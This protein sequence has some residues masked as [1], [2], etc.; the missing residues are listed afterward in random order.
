MNI[1][2]L[3]NSRFGVGLAITLCRLLPTESG[4]RLASW[5][6]RNLANRK[7]LDLVRALR[8]NQWVASGCT[9]SSAELDRRV[10]Q[11][12]AH[13]ARCIFDLYHNLH[14]DEIIHQMIAVS[15]KNYEFLAQ[16]Q[17]ASEGL[18]LGFLHMSNFDF[19]AQAAGMTG[20]KATLLAAEDPGGGGYDL[21]NRLR[22]ESGLNVMTATKSAVR[23][24]IRLLQHGGTVATGLDRPYPGLNQHPCFFGRPSNLPLLPVILALQAKVPV[25][26]GAIMLQEDNR[27][28]IN[29]S[30]RIDMIEL[31]NHH[32]ELVVNYE[33]L[34]VFA[35]AYIRRAPYQW[36]MTYPVWPEVLKEMP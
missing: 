7:K 12:F 3:I 2:E 36:S 9:L 23:E 34:L 4:Y 24:A 18:V 14:D 27:Y 21:Q 29:L 5:L 20:L 25:H 28:H 26:V 31:S 32:D 16:R 1:Q 30:E 19:I 35:E 17:N 10:E 15:P 6:G 11:C 8:A 33:R 22:E 13:T